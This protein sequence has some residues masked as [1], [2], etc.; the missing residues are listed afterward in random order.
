MK[1]VNRRTF[2]LIRNIMIVLIA[3]GIILAILMLAP[4][5]KNVDITDQTNLVINNSNVTAHLKNKIIIRDGTVYLSRADI[6]N[7]FD[8]Y[9]YYDKDAKQIITTYETKVASLFLDNPSITVNGKEY[10]L[11]SPAIKENDTVYLPFSLMEDVYNAEITYAESTDTAI[12]ETLS[13]EKITAD[14]VKDVPVRYK[15]KTLSRKVDEVK[16]GDSVVIISNMDD[17]WIKVRTNN[18]KIGYVKDSDLTNTQTVREDQEEVK[19]IEGKVNMVW[20]NFYVSAPDRSGTTIPGINVVSPTFFILDKDGKGSFSEAVGTEGI[21]YIN[22]AKANNYKVWALISNIRNESMIKTTSEIMNSYENRSTLI[23]NILKA[24]K[25]Y[26]LD[27]ININFEYMYD[28]DVDMFT[29]FL[30]ELYPRMKEIG[31]VLSVDVTAPDGSAY[32]SLCF[33]RHDIAKN[34]DYI[35][36]MAYDQHTLSGGKVGSTA[37][38]DWVSSNVTK[39]L[40]R[41]EIESNKLILAIPFYT[42]LWDETYSGDVSGAIADMRNISKVLPSGIE[43]VWLDDARQ[44]YVE[45]KENNLTHK[46]WIEDEKSIREKLSIVTENNLG[47]AAFW[48]KD[49]E[50][51]GIWDTIDEILN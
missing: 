9:I 39:F 34:C 42:I 7:F 47:G 49:R 6:D 40:D 43:K 17:G 27:G 37:A 13:K 29:Q 18:G 15:M 14:T 8:P 25:N 11:S 5:Y 51:E 46:M 19:Q 3:L 2:K 48:V 32:Y 21:N 50:S 26:Q 30:V 23:N 10:T 41:E 22:W 16:K 28:T 20:D 44:Y 35:V 45:Y 36:F 33:N 1:K 12:V 4:N 31:A 24:V 38:Y